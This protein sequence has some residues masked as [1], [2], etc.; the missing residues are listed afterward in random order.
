MHDQGTRFTDERHAELEKKLRRVYRQAQEEIAQKL[1]EHT[2]R[3]NAKAKVKLAQVAAGTL[4]QEEFDKWQAGQTFIGKQWKD[5]VTSC[6]TTLMHANEQ[7]NAMIEG[8]KR[9]VFGEN[10]TYQAYQLEHD[11]GL[12]LSFNVYDSATV[13]RLLDEEPELLPRKRVNGRKDQAWNRRNISNAVTQGIIQGESVDKIAKRIAKQT[14]SKN[15][16]AM[17]RYARTALTSAQN[18]GRMEML[19]EAQDMGIKVKKKWLATLDKRTRDVHRE[20]DGQVVDVDEPFHSSLGDIMYPGDPAA[21][22]GNVYNCRCTL[23][24]VYP[25]YMPENAERRAYNEDRTESEVI[26][27][28]T[29]NEWKAWK[30]GVDNT[31][32]TEAK[33]EIFIPAKTRQEAEEYAKRFG[34]KVDYS[35]ISVEN[36]NKINETMTDLTQKYP[37]NQLDHITQTAQA[38]VARANYDHLEIDGKKLGKVLS[39][40]EELF[41]KEQKETQ[42][43]I[44]S[45]RS[46]YKAKLPPDVQRKVDLLQNKL[47]YTRYGVHSSYDDHV[48]ALITHEYGHILADQY[49]GQINGGNANPHYDLNWSLR[50]MC[51]KWDE[52]YTQALTTGDIYK[53]SKYGSK[54]VKEFFAESFAAYEMGEKLPSYVASLLK[55]VLKNGIM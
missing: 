39:R 29:Y 6:A 25:E 31:E 45:I 37:I 40:D 50:D 8:E 23:V 1:D 10:M 32:K 24:Y 5:K 12:D 7:A 46:R 38:S 41:L 4:T 14:A 28:M 52:A 2:K 53:L 16:D 42:E 36:C 34:I 33:K 17:T 35:G 18:A 15:M 30:A 22:P 54:N 19:H 3:M 43:L 51:R 49:F 48:R 26:P 21:E 20:L 27:D 55:E 13:T 47:Q 44:D 9:A 11:A